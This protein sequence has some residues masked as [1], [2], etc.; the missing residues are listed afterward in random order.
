[1]AQSPVSLQPRKD[2][3]LLELEAA[4]IREISE[5]LF[6]KLDQKVKAVEAVEISLD[7]KI[8]LLAQLIQKAESF[9]AS[10]SSFKKIEQVDQI[11]QA[12]EAI[13]ASLDKKI[14]MLGLL[15]QKAEPL[16]ASGNGSGG[17]QNRQHEIIALQ[18][19]G[20]GIKEIAEVLDLPQGEVGLIIN[21]H[22]L[23]A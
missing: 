4:E 12:G 20:M 2:K 9:N 6:R 16:S 5:L 14:A 10:S 3:D 7:K 19:K 15:L 8:A 11:V 1:M 21:L 22:A 23:P 18:Q 13:G 17:T